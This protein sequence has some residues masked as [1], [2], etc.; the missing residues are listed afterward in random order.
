[1]T[2]LQNDDAST[3]PSDPATSAPTDQ[4]SSASSETE[5]LRQE[6]A[7]LTNQL[8]RERADF[9]NYRSRTRDEW[10]DWLRKGKAEAVLALVPVIEN[11]SRALSSMPTGATEAQW[12]EALSLIIQLGERQLAQL[13]VE[14]I[15]S[16][17][18]DFDSSLHEAVSQAEGKE[19]AVLHEVEP[20][21]LLEGKPISAAKVVI[22]KDL[23]STKSE[24]LENGPEPVK[25]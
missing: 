17:G 6:I 22:G 23:A 19:G 24:P 8:Q 7:D 3:Q 16:I 1:M 4:G 13:K 20:G 21:Y 15:A 2:T 18:A 11:L 10:Q 25:N 12:K 9:V 5:K 14:R